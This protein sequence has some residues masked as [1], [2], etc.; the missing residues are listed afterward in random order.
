MRFALA[1]VAT[2]ALGTAASFPVLGSFRVESVAPPRATP[3]F[4][5]E[6]IPP[7][8]FGFAWGPA[9][10]P[11][12]RWLLEGLEMV[13]RL[14]LA[15]GL[16]TLAI[17]CATL[18]VLYV[19]QGSER[20]S[21]I[22]VH[23]A[24]GAN[25]MNLVRALLREPVASTGVGAILGGGLGLAGWMLLRAWWPAGLGPPGVRFSPL[26]L[27]AI[28]IPCL[29]V[30]LAS[31]YPLRHLR[32]WLRAPGLARV[33]G[34]LWERM[35]L[36][37]YVA[38]LVVFLTVAG[39]L[40]RGQKAGDAATP[41]GL[42]TRDTLV[43][44]VRVTEGF[45]PPATLEAITTLPDTRSA[46][47]VSTGALRGIGMT[48]GTVAEC[49]CSSGGLPAP[50][51]R[52]IP[53][54][55]VVSPGFF[56][57]MGIP[58]DRGRDFA[59]T[60]DGGHPPV[61]IINRALAAMIRGAD[62]LDARIRIGGGS[63]RG[64]WYSVIGVVPDLYPPGLGT[65]RQPAPSVYLSS[66]QHAPSA[67]TLL[68][69]SE[70]PG[71]I[72]SEVRAAL[73]QVVPGAE[74]TG[75]TTVDA[76]LQRWRAPLGWFA[77]L[78][79]LLAAGALV[80]AAH[81]LHSAIALDVWRRTPE[82]GVRRAVGATWH[83]IGRTVVLESARVMAPGLALGFAAAVGFARGLETTVAGIQPADPALYT[84]I[85]AILLGSAVTG[86]WVPARRAGRLDPVHAIASPS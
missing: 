42:E 63:L 65:S 58:V 31:L 47:L 37:C 48:D 13:A 56:T 18:T 62:P 16:L 43:V 10:V 12:D 55:H 81:G 78:T 61:A 57:Q 20:H 27:L 1:V 6:S 76:L 80:L 79:A 19:R 64:P 84:V 22:V 74:V 54:H 32:V 15:L 33:R 34:A 69:R 9:V 41:F 30:L 49:R 3:M 50:Y 51:V 23:A 36:S 5:A 38:S 72:E 4:R 2:Q 29:S 52:L 77:G 25:R 39:L 66:S 26:A 68:I 21:E 11:P 44:D 67:A 82:L 70:A 75:V 86:A 35:V 46:S 40:L 24:V 60:D 7:N 85:A 14:W 53:Q 45:D 8:D 71:R 59:V 83:D 17:T 73:A 28:A